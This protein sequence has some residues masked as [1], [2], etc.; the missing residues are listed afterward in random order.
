[1]HESAGIRTDGAPEEPPLEPGS[2]EW[3][4]HLPVT[5]VDSRDAATPDAWVPRHPELIRLTGRCCMQSSI[6]HTL[7]CTLQ[8][9]IK[10]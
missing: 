9:G 4:V 1:M 10:Q 6:A 7:P 8:E 5:H 3:D 2:S